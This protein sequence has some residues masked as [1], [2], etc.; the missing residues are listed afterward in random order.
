MYGYRHDGAEREQ[1]PLRIKQNVRIV[2][3][4]CQMYVYVRA[5]VHV[6]ASV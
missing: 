1:L 5:S 4:R 2:L 3:V 6:C